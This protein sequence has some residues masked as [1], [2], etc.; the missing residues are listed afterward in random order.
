M[1]EAF[2]D[3]INQQLVIYSHFIFYG[4]SASAA[5]AEQVA[6]EIEQLWNEPK[7]VLNKNGL[8]LIIKFNITAEYIADISPDDVHSNLNSQLNFFRV[9]PFSRLHISFVDEVGSNTGYFL[10]DNLLN[11]STTAAHEYGHTL[12]LQHPAMLDIRGQGQPGIMYPR[13]TLVDAQYQW[14]PQ[15]AAGD[16]GGTLNPAYRKVTA[17]DIVQLDLHRLSYN[18]EGKAIVGDFTNL[19]HMAH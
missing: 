1:G 8:P 10:L 16:K 15:V 17:N 13:G 2:A 6:G 19:Y 3:N 5:L 18:Q 9:E 4:A 12:G 7:A 11:N 14:D